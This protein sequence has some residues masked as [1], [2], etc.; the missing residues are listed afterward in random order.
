M[1]SPALL[2]IT[3][4]H[5]DFRT[6]ASLPLDTDG[7]LN[8]LIHPLDKQFGLGFGWAQVSFRAS[9]GFRLSRQPRSSRPVGTGSR[10]QTD[11]NDF[12][13]EIIRRFWI[14]MVEGSSIAEWN[15]QPHQW[16]GMARAS[17]SLQKFRV[18]RG[19]A[20]VFVGLCS[21]SRWQSLSIFLV[22]SSIAMHAR[23]ALY[24]FRLGRQGEPR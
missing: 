6:T 18:V 23:I 21:T 12:V 9:G 11:L 10:H 19:H 15:S 14:H 16:T 22:E 7:P 5:D 20:T 24:A 8:E 3:V 1:G 4:H 2:N 17:A 13:L